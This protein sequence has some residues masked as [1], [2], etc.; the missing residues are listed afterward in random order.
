MKRQS[1]LAHVALATALLA[2]PGCDG[3]LTETPYSSLTTDIFYTNRNDAVAAVLS[4]YKQ[5]ADAR[6]TGWQAAAGFEGASDMANAHPLDQNPPVQ[7]PANLSWDPTN[8]YVSG[9]WEPLYRLI[10]RANLV[11]EKVPETPGLSDADKQQFMA[12]MK[13]LRAWSYNYLE[14]MYGDVPILLSTAESSDSANYARDPHAQVHA[15][16]LKDATEA[17]AVLPATRPAGEW[18][19]ATKGAA[20]ALIADRYLWNASR[21]NSGEWQQASDWAKR[22][23]DSGTYSLQSNY[24]NAFLPTNK[25][26][27]EVIFA[28][29]S[30]GIDARSSNNLQNAYF[31]RE[32]S[33][34]GGFG[35]VT[36]TA[37]AYASVYE[38]GDYRKEVNFRTSGCNTTGTQCFP[39]A[40]FPNGF[41]QGPHPFKYRPSTPSNANLTDVDWII[42]RVADMWLIYSEAQFKLGNAGEAVR[43][44]NVLRARARQ[45]TGSENR[46]VPADLASSLSGSAL[47]DAIYNE[48]SRELIWENKRWLDLVRRDTQDPGYWASQ[49]ASHDAATTRFYQPSTQGFRKLWPIP[50]RELD[51]LPGI[52]TQ[53]PGY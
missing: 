30:S 48:R 41:P 11:M 47:Y 8:I 21:W 44:L 37:W 32:L 7:A 50:Q 12:E 40:Q 26:N 29:T 16:I 35:V 43:A 22:V 24:I 39:N 19:R 4:A 15:Q 25:G 52:L 20:R 9:E 13:F 28:R 42:Y 33:P 27:S 53:N 6:I 3:M 17:E 5:M 45:G 34:G 46:A 2:A 18:G 1:L 51:L 31:P 10:F 49:L 14:R 38:P 23:I 36:P